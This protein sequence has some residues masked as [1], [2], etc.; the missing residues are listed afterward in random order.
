MEFKKSN[1]IILI[2]Y[3]H[4]LYVNEL[5]SSEYIINSNAIST[6]KITLNLLSRQ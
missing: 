6:I 5:T 1:F 2:K 4:K 3:L